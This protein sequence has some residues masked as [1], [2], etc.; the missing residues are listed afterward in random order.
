M[1]LD[2]NFRKRDGEGDSPL[3]PGFEPQDVELETPSPSEVKI[4]PKTGT[5]SITNPD[6]SMIV[7]F[8]PQQPGEGQ[9]DADA[10]VHDANLALH[11]DSAELARIAS[12]VLEGI[13][14]DI[15]DRQ[16][17][18]D[19]RAKGINL[20]GLELKEPGTGDQQAGAPLQG[21]SVIDH[22]LLLEAV[23]RFQANARGELLPAGGPVKVRDDFVPV[24][25]QALN[26]ANVV[27][28]PALAASPPPGLPAPP[29]MAGPP[30]AM[31]GPPPAPPMPPPGLAGGPGLPPPEAMGVPMPGVQAMGGNGGPPMGP[32]FSR[33]EMAEV[34]EGDMNHYLTVRAKEYVP[35]TDRMLLMVGL[36]G[37]GF[38]KVYKCP[39]RRRPVSESVD[40]KDL[41]VSNDATDLQNA[42]RVTHQ[43]RM[44]KSTV[45]RMQLAGAYRKPPGV[46]ELAQPTLD[47]TSIDQKVAAIQGLAAVPQR[48]EDTP[49]TI[50]E[51]YCELDIKGFEHSDEYG[52][53]GLAVPYVVV[54]DKDTREILAVRRNWEEGDDMMAPQRPFVKYPFVPGLGFYDI[55][56]VHI[57]GNTT[58]AMTALWREMIDAG[59][60]ANFPGFL[61]LKEAMHNQKTPD[62]RVPPGGGAGINGTGGDISKMVM[63]IPYKT[64]DAAFLQFIGEVAK[65]GQ[66]VG[67]TAEVAVGDGRQDAPVGTTIALMEQATKI[68]D[69]VHKR[70]YAAQ[71]EEFQLLKNLFK[72]DPESL[73]R[74]HKK[75]K[76]GEKMRVAVSPDEKLAVKQAVIA[77]LEDNDIVPAADPNTPSHMHRIMKA[78]AILQLAQAAPDLYDMKEVHK[79]VHE[80]L[81][82]EDYRSMFA[83]PPP[84]PQPSPDM[85]L[86]VQGE[87]EKARMQAESDREIAQLKADT[88]LRKARIAADSK[89][90]EQEHK[91]TM[92]VVD[93]ARD[94]AKQH[95]ANRATSGSLA[96]DRAKLD[97]AAAAK[98]EPPKRTI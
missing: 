60:F 72:Q 28:D 74:G 30:G 77:A 44:R 36:G 41:I 8:A 61:Y 21:M 40:A 26:P 5:A 54:I 88:D 56:L 53:T 97:A 48:P 42:A 78:V 9:Q 12:E 59:M 31:P 34:L 50:Y 2:Y 1:G 66:G 63:P 96:N 46:I 6:G 35:D 52:P 3:G 33:A 16:Q 89:A 57:L 91:T 24:D 10:M 87:L 76:I 94:I 39:I 82:T 75:S 23:L 67:G 95:D 83:A 51:C 49:Y 47:V 81:K 27:P 86:G 58:R 85:Q 20:L 17:W 43:I 98:K 84:P 18:V 71:A 55:G 4:D 14:A 93:T 64:P 45:K 22:P 62:F 79:R 73:W 11:I 65:T 19:T 92:A 25:D 15:A 32:P 13:D 90:Q 68:V 38:K 37:C 29:P 69:A 80:M 7:D 70:L